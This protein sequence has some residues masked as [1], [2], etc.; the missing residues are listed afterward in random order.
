[1][2]EA[3]RQDFTC[4]YL[5]FIPT[6]HEPCIYRGEIDGE[7]VLFKRQVDD[8][9]LGA[10]SVTTATKVWDLIDQQLRMPMKRQGLVSMY[11]GLDILQSCWYVKVSIQ[12]WLAIMMEPYFNDWL[13][14]PSSPMPTPLGPNEAFIKRLYSTEGDPSVAARAQ[15]EK[16][17]GIKYRKAIGQLIWP[18][19]TC[20][21]D[22]AQTTVKLAQH[23]A[24]SAEVHYCGVKSVFR[25][26]AATMDEGIIFWRTEPCMELPDDPLPKIWSTPHDI[27]L[28]N[29]PLDDPLILSGS[30]DSGWGSCLL[31]RRSFGSVMMRMSGGPVA[32]KAR[33]H[34][35]VAGSSTEAEFMMAYDGGRMSLYL[36]SILWDL[37]VPQDAATILYEDND[38]ATAMANAGKPTPRTCHIDI[39]YYA[40]QEWVERDLVVLRRIDT[41]VNTADHLTKPLSRILF[42]RHRDFYMGHVPP[43][44]SPRY[45]EVVRVYGLLDPSNPAFSQPSTVAAKAAKSMGPW[46]MVIQSLY[47][48]PM[49]D[50][51]S[52]YTRSLERG[53]VTDTYDSGTLSSPVSLTLVDRPNSII[54]S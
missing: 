39:K 44:Y 40:L 54:R 5:G 43:T 29:R 30:M 48:L 31:T 18:M 52:N 22:L 6:V 16:Q 23:S 50:F 24:A 45:N 17:M 34:P 26:L 4:P 3:Y 53:G 2:G 37:G 28:V 11:N 42:Y 49:A 51:R 14:I 46:D 13:D 35:S 10:K 33:L 27:K 8:F 12:T 9:L 36:H 32:Y 21:P 7:R 1:V 20:R 19:T 38:G 41:S 47:L 25:Y 15:L